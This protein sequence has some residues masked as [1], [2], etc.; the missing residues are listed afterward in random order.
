MEFD[1]AASHCFHGGFRHVGHDDEPLVGEIGLDGRLGAVGM[2]DLRGVR[3][4][5]QKVAALFQGFHDERTRFQSVHAGELPGHFVQGP[6]GIEN[7]DF[8]QLVPFAAKVV[9]GVVGGRHLY[10]ARAEFPVNQQSVADNGYGALDQRQ[11][12]VLADQMFVAFVLGMHSHGGV[13]EESFRAG[14]RHFQIFVAA[15]NLVL[16]VPE[17]ALHSFIDYF[18]VRNGSL[19]L[20]VPVDQSFAPV[21]EAGFE[22]GEESRSDRFG[23]DGVKR[24]AQMLPV[25]GTAHG[26]ELP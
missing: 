22:H 10:A 25:A 12:N 13:A 4:S 14:G 8:R 16:K 11:N 7:V 20:D 23:A 6:V 21:D 24:E 5:L 15:F 18:V 2:A 17:I 9:V 1:L 26:P 19:K 3:L